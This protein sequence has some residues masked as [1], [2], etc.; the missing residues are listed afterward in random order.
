[1]G[2]LNN[3]INDLV[4]HIFSEK[5]FVCP[6]AFHYQLGN[7]QLAYFG[8]LK[9]FGNKKSFIHLARMDKAVFLNL[10]GIVWGYILLV[11][12]CVSKYPLASNF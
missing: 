8:V 11:A 1:M 3:I 9:S 6:T 12:H 4:L 2:I 5:D 10:Q 7:L